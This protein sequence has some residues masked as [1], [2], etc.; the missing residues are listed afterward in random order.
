MMTQFSFLH[1][2]QTGSGYMLVVGGSM[3]YMEIIRAT[4]RIDEAITEMKP[5]KKEMG[6]LVKLKTRFI[7]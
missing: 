5:R 6:Y 7:D 2:T 3:F 4:A 1:I